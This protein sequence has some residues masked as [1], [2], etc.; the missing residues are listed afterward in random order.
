MEYGVSVQI[1]RSRDE[2]LEARKNTIGGSD[3]AAVLGVNP[4]MS[5]VDLWEIKTGRKAQKDVSN[6]PVVQYGTK[7]EA[8]LRELFKLDHPEMNV[9]Y[10][11]NNLWSNP[12]YPFAHYSADGWLWEPETQK[13]GILEIKTAEMLGQSSWL[14]W[15]GGV[16]LNYFAQLIQGLA[17]TGRDFAILKAQLKYWKDDRLFITTREY[18]YDRDE[19]TEANIKYLMTAE[20]QL[21]EGIQ[22]GKRPPLILPQI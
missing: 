15:E 11:E 17:V 7:A 12:E 8:P 18:R 20:E 19:N 22:S 16:P 2:W 13:T 6:V 1:F 4:W 10:E 14:K 5:N 9:M 3:A 21:W